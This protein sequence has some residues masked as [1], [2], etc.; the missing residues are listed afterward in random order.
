MIL[1]NDF[2]EYFSGVMLIIFLVSIF[3]IVVFKWP[4]RLI[5]IN[6]PESHSCVILY[7]PLLA[8]FAS[9]NYPRQNIFDVITKYCPCN[10]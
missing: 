3:I 4:W 7:V 8:G 6:I 5:L 10:I 1:I 9:T 2:N